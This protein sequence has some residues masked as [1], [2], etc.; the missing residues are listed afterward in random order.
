M[1][2]LA[3]GLADRNNM[4]VSS[5]IESCEHAAAGQSGEIIHDVE[6]GRC[7]LLGVGI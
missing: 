2:G 4:K 5:T 1:V 6:Q 3:D 7:I